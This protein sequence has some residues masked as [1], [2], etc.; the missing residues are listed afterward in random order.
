MP[1]QNN[2][3]KQNKKQNRPSVRGARGEILPGDGKTFTSLMSVPR[4]VCPTPREYDIT[5]SFS[6]KTWFT[7]SNA[8]PTFTTLYVALSNFG[9]AASLT[10]IFDQ[11]MID[12][13][14]MWLFPVLS[15][16]ASTVNGRLITVIDIDDGTNLTTMDQADQYSSSVT[17]ELGQ[18]HYRHF[19]PHIA[20][21]A[22]NGA[23][24]AF[25]NKSKQW[26][27]AASTTVQHYG[28][29]VAADV[30]ANVQTFDLKIRAR[31]RFRSV[32]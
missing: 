24:G 11:Y 9:D 12:D 29:K 18:G 19:C 14:E 1:R 25:A 28:V 13:V 32:H 17:S 3:Q 15:A 8:L 5:Q 22:Y 7:T 20:L 6:I 4:T 31:L 27:D 30:N 16:G 23:F 26:I 21:S 2:K 10:A